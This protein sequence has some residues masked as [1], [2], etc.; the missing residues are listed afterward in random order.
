MIIINIRKI[1]NTIR[2]VSITSYIVIDS[3][4]ISLIIVNTIIYVV[5]SIT[6]S[7]S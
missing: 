3:I 1:N 2:S 6:Y 4:R 7:Y 5:T